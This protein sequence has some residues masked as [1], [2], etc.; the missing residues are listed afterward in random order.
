MARKKQKAYKKNQIQNFFSGKKGRLYLFVLVFGVFGLA[1]LLKTSALIPDT[2]GSSSRSKILAVAQYQLGQKEVPLGSD[3]GPMVSVYTQ[4]N[5]EP[6]C[7]DFVSWVYKTAGFPFHNA[8]NGP[9]W[10]YSVASKGGIGGWRGYSILTRLADT[11]RFK[12]R[13]TYTPIKGDI[14]VFNENTYYSH[15]G[16]VEKILQTGY[17]PVVQTIEGNSENSVKRNLY[18]IN[19]NRILGYGDMF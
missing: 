9:G 19:D 11:G 1:Y 7:A 18:G 17:G 4:G 14:I 2:G 5:S 10:R 6:W 8:I 3:R 15:V 13:G 12:A 16:I